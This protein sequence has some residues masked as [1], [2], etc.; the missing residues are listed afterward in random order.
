M[1]SLRYRVLLAIISFG[2][3]IAYAQNTPLIVKG[4]P[5]LL[6]SGP[7]YIPLEGPTLADLD[8]DGQLDIVI[9]SGKKIYALHSDGTLLAGWPQQTTYETK[10][11]PAIG[12]LDGDD[13][14]EIVTIDR[15]FFT[16]KTFLYAWD[17]QGKLL[18]NFP[19]ELNDGNF[20][21]A[22]FDLDHDGKLEIIGSFADK[23]C[24][25]QHDGSEAMGWPKNLTP[26]TPA[27]KAAVG[28]INADGV[29][30]IVLASAARSIQNGKPVDVGRLYAW[31]ANGDLLPGWPVETPTGY[32]FADRCNPSL[33]DLK[34][35]GF[36][37]IA[38]GSSDFAPPSYSAFAALYQHDGTMMPGWPKYTIGSD[39]LADFAVGPAIADLD[40]D[41]EPDLIFADILDHIIAWKGNGELVAGWPI[42]LHKI[43]STLFGFLSTLASPSVGD[44]DGDAAPEIFINSNQTDL[45]NGNWL[46]RIYALNHDATPLP[47]S[48]IRTRRTAA[49]NAVAMNDLNRDG[50]LE[51]V[52]VSSEAFEVEETWLTV[53][54][55]PGV[56][57]VEERFPWPMYGHDRWHTSQYGF[58][59][60]DEP[61]VAVKESEERD[62]LPKDFVLHQNYPNPFYGAGSSL[63]GLQNRTEIS[64]QLPVM[65]HVELRVFN[66]LGKE[67]RRLVEATQTAGTH[68]AQWDGKDERGVALPVGVYFYRMEA[69]PQQRGG[70]KT[71]FIKKLTLLN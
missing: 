48:P 43:D 53:W 21:V 45:V 13:D 11:S 32:I 70:E 15:D 62:R 27:S 61:T 52:T 3:P 36:M 55:I 42:S 47:W 58:K 56:P 71:S 30:D 14:L 68:K 25:F 59:P 50:T 19:L 63:R 67:V 17:W 40:Q 66:L 1:T 16:P 60:P 35:D 6:E 54:E 38:V 5:V 31:N 41:G 23:V 24:I 12:D 20:A 7:Q 65:S 22:L 8:R 46:G 10:N 64:Y 49:F 39:S 26:F 2:M 44:I 51:F 29:I 69:T 4:F 34:S 9:A 33:L 28:D 57:Y 18:T 37:E